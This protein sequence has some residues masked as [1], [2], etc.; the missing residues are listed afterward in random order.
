MG[1]GRGAAGLLAGGG[2]L[3]T[4]VV[5]LLVAF[6]PQRHG[7]TWNDT[8]RYVMTVERLLGHDAAGAQAS[9]L[10]WYCTDEARTSAGATDPARCVA[11]WTKIGGLAPNTARYN[12]IFIARPG[13]PLLVAPF[14]ALFGLSAGLAVVA[15]LVTIA[16]GWLCLLLAR[17]SG[18]GVTGS[19]CS[20]VAIYC[21]PTFFWL[22]QYLTE[23]PMLDCTLA[24]L[25]G[26][27]LVLRERVVAG[28]VVSTL[29]YAAGLL[30]R[31]ST[32]SLQ[33][34]CLTLCLLVLALVGPAALRVGRTFRLAGYHAGV[35]VIL[36]V[37]PL[38]LGW[39][40]FRESL[41]DTFT[42]HFTE[43]EPPDLYGHWF[44]LM[45]RYI[46]SLGRL[47]GGDPV[48][49]LAVIA[50]AVLLWRGQR[51]LAAVVTA[52]ALTGVGTA[53]AHPVASQGSRLYVQ[54]FLLVVFGLGLGADLAQRALAA[55]L[56][57]ER[58]SRV[59]REDE[60]GDVK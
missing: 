11:S 32:F 31:Y 2:L 45:G 25:I 35:F 50:S 3:I 8:Y 24:L 15:W 20:M 57:A 12:E 7:T 5:G 43:T 60:V 34:A 42:D 10:R 1:K 9:A 37:V 59:R 18:L 48:L 26:T 29:A 22:Q 46:S 58:V 28:L 30:I 53:L 17:L 47:Y 56:A 33:S 13:Y 54:V 4:L 19:L 27:V 39:P 16:A 21:L 44:T 36:T 23:G 51:L 14:A 40:G 41:T 49:P 52:A 55:R 6:Q 38:L